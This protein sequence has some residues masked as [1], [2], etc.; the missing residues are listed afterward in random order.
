MSKE[1]A[2][3]RIEILK[4]LR[5]QH[6][7]SVSATQALL[8]ELQAIRKEIR[9]AM[10]IEPRTVPELAATTGLPANEVLWHVI[11]MKKYNLVIETGLDD[12]YYRY[13]LAEEA[14]K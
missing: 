9:Q 2:R 6:Q 12:G 8:K 10:Q 3:N 13:S 11:A 1:D 14:K 7:A 4:R 5:E